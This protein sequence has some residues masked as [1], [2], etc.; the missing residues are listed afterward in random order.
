MEIYYWSTEGVINPWICGCCNKSQT[1]FYINI[2]KY[3]NNELKLWTLLDVKVNFMMK[4]LLPLFR[5][6]HMLLS[7]D[8]YSPILFPRLG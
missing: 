3:F 5:R 8:K 7:T 6:I 1:L 4:V 2:C